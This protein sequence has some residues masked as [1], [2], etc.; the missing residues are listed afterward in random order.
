M[1]EREMFAKIAEESGL[2][3]KEEQDPFKAK[4]EKKQIMEAVRKKIAK[5]M[6]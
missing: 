3:I 6:K 5:K 4:E 2:K 1:N